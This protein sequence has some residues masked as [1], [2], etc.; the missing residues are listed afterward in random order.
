MRGQVL[1]PEL[2]QRLTDDEGRRLNIVL[3]RMPE[4]PDSPTRRIDGRHC[5]GEV[6]ASWAVRIGIRAGDFVCMQLSR[7][8]G[9]LIDFKA[10]I[11]CFEFRSILMRW[12]IPGELVAEPWDLEPATPSL[13]VSPHPHPPILHLPEWEHY[14]MEVPYRVSAGIL[15]GRSGHLLIERRNCIQ[16]LVFIMS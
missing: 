12:R 10:A 7:Q 11:L 9:Y 15:A 14:P 16:D 3:R 13:M 4:E 2:R 5:H 8:E 1:T 6:P